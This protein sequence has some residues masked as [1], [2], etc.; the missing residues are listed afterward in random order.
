M[1]KLMDK[2]IIAILRSKISLNWPYVGV[3]LQEECQQ[4]LRIGIRNII[5]SMP[6]GCRACVAVCEGHI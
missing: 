4:T 5:S 1:F 2:K 3:A 6:D